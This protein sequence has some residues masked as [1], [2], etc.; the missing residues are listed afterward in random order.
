MRILI[1]LLAAM[2]LLATA[3]LPTQQQDS[4]L[5]P[6]KKPMPPATVV[7]SGGGGIPTDGTAMGKQLKSQQAPAST[8]P[9][10]MY[11]EPGKNKPTIITGPNGTTI[12]TD[13]SGK[14]VVCW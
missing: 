12:C 11:R 8:G 2:P 1:L 3:Q 10:W 14:V 5:H 7:E 9:T 4:V 6:Y 13:A